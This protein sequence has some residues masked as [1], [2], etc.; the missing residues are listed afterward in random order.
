MSASYL[1]S[2]AWK[3]QARSSRSLIEWISVALIVLSIIWPRQGFL[4]L[5]GGLKATPFTALATISWVLL[6]FF[7]FSPAF[8]ARLISGL[9]RYRWLVIAF[10]MWF[11]WRYLA[12]MFGQAPS[13][14]LERV[15][16]E[17]VFMGPLLPFAIY[18]GETEQGQ[19]TLLKSIIFATCIVCAIGAFELFQRKTFGPLFGLKFVGDPATVASLSL[20]KM[21][22]SEIRLQ[23]SFVHPLVFGQYLVWAVPFVLHKLLKSSWR[24]KWFY[25]GLL[26][27]CTWL[28][29]ETGSRGAILALPCGVAAYL[30]LL[31]LQ[32]LRARGVAAW[33]LIVYL[34]ISAFA[35]SAYSSGTISSL[36]FGRNSIETQ[37]TLMR[38]KMF[39]YGIEALKANPVIG[40]GDGLATLYTGGLRGETG[41]L[42]VDSA[43]LS[44]AID[45]GYIGVFL[46]VLAW[47][48]VLFLA[49]NSALG[50]QAG[51]F[52]APVAGAVLTLIIVFSVL[53]IPDGLTL[54]FLAIPLIGS[55]RLSPTQYK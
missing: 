51:E 34:A 7:F 6:A 2:S 31:W 8:R 27:V 18:L 24:T 48:G 3:T 52:D 55:R 37:S 47:V 19:S 14:S 21:R 45:T 53:S 16:R 54:F 36:V 17:F 40:F 32:Q 9:R 26:G 1:T 22:G 46:L 38:A 35:I 25:V 23:S 4:A 20:H 33:I 15:T 30:G 11:L 43:F 29:L 42:T 5:P 28:V 49:V 50:R 12:A 13:L 39:E 44:S 41:S 10:A